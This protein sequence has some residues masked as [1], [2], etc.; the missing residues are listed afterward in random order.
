MT[1]RRRPPLLSATGR[2]ARSARA[3]LVL[4]AFANSLVVTPAK[5]QAVGIDNLV[6]PAGA[7]RIRA[8]TL[9][10]VEVLGRGPVPLILIP[11]AP[12]TWRVWAGF[13]ARNADR[14]T[15]Y[16]I[17]LPGYGGTPVPVARDDSVE[18]RDW[19]LGVVAALE[20][21]VETRRLQ[22][23]VIVANH[24]MAA[25]YAVLLAGR[26]ECRIG[27]IVAIASDPI[28][29]DPLQYAVPPNRDE[30]RRSLRERWMPFYRSLDSASWFRGAY[31]PRALSDDP[32]RAVALHREQM[33]PPLY[34]QA[35]Y[36]LEF[37]SDDVSET[38][39][40]LRVPMLS[41][42]TRFDASLLP[43]HV[44]QSLVARWGDRD[45]VRDSLSRSAFWPHR[46]G[47][48]VPSL[49]VQYVKNTGA[50][51]MDDDPDLIDRLVADFVAARRDCS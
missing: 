32:A 23:P 49:S 48:R 41:V 37:V 11:G 27:G 18:K 35:R 15:M 29:G 2:R 26:L 34:A 33:A 31:G 43:D 39:Q 24:L 20:N 36:Y 25:Y 21:L 38:L 44:L 6:V 42:V 17:T 19:T 47:L 46:F 12:F 14:Y 7:A 1:T 13:A 5:A 16:G 40:R 45:T 50:V 9:G 22:R 10:H 4:G 28:S 8:G 30:R 51:M 3:F